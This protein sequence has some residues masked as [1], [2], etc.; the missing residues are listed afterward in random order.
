[1]GLYSCCKVNWSVSYGIHDSCFVK[2]AY[3]AFT[4]K[5]CLEAF[6]CVLMLGKQA[7]DSS[8]PY[9]EVEVFSLLRSLGGG[10]YTC[11]IVFL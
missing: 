7:K 2:G 9:F 1:M 10:L 8:A 4:A 5:V 3:R 11:K 6:Y